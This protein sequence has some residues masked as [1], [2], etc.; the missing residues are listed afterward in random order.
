VLFR[1]GKARA[2]PEVHEVLHKEY[3]TLRYNMGKTLALQSNRYHRPKPAQTEQPDG[4]YH[5][6]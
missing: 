6:A 1:K 4:G 2:S 5:D 3:C